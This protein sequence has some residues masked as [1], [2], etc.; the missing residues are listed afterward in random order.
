[1]KPLYTLSVDLQFFAGEKT[2]K[3]TPR[4]REDS[5]KKGQV[6]KSADLTGAF[7]LLA[8]F[9]MLSF[10][11]PY[12]GKQLF[13]VTKDL[14]GPSYLLFDLSNGLSG[15]LTDLLLRVGLI[16]GPFF[17]VAVI[18]GILINYLQIGTL[19]SAE[20]IQPKL[21]RIDPIK[22]VKRI[23]SMKAVVEFL[24]SL[25]KLLIIL[26]T[27]VAVLWQNQ[28]ELS[29]M[30]VE[31][32]RE[33]VIALAHITIELGLWVS[34]ALLALALLD[35]FYQ[36]FDFEKSIRMSKQDIKDEYKNSEGDPLIKSKIK[37]QQREMAM[38][39][40]MQEIP[41]ADVVITNPTHY[42]VVIRYDDTKD[43]APLVVAKGVDR[44]AFNI[45][46]VA[47]EHDIPIVENKPLARALYAQM[48]IGE[49]V[50]ESFYQ[51]IAEVLAFVY[52]L[53]Q[54]S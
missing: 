29:R 19:F 31:H 37:Q 35:F 16:V 45:R 18:F 20:A 50:D 36:R 43:F 24:K 49:V 10:L 26:T 47:K 44:V 12:L 30:A 40:M 39:R 9:L 54:P 5:R 51:A 42:A 11:G 23:I 32:I 1:M 27:A 8:M 28:K 22:G 3:A 38:R 2:E 4:K 6:A 41:N 25:F 14:L 7:A 15:M 13:S 46:D 33:S 21:E 48:D 17:A 52:Q 34:V 53:K